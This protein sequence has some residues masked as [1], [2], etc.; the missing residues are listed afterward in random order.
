MRLHSGTVKA[1]STSTPGPA[2]AMTYTVTVHLPGGD[3]DVANVRPWNPQ[4]PDT[5]MQRP[6]PLSTIVT[7]HELGDQWRFE[8]PMPVPETE[9][10]G[11]GA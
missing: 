6:Y 1:R 4:W 7:V 2:S 3:T 5:V 8:F 9:E 10:C 11:G